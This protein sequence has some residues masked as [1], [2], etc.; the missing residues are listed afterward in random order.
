MP[1]TDLCTL[2][3]TD[4]ADIL[5][6]ALSYSPV[7]FVA[8]DCNWGPPVSGRF[9]HDFLLDWVATDVRLRPKR[10]SLLGARNQ[11][12]WDIEVDLDLV[13]TVGVW[14][15]FFLLS[16]G[17]Q[18]EFPDRCEIRMEGE[19]G[20][21][22]HDNYGGHGVDYRL[23]PYKGRMTSSIIGDVAKSGPG[24]TYGAIWLLLKFTHRPDQAERRVPLGRAGH[25]R[26]SPH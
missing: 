19:D 1:R 15:L 11:T 26:H 10:V 16:L 14:Q 18:I 13:S 12:E 8:I 17:S 24:A 6:P 21:I 25:G 4:V 20:A 5:M 23:V 22:Y 3:G 7:H 2:D 9:D